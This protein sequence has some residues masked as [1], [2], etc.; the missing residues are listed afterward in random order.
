MNL[1]EK[2]I[3]YLREQGEKAKIAQ[4]NHR[5]KLTRGIRRMRIPAYLRRIFPRRHRNRLRILRL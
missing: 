4:R 1:K 5:A 3:R 2:I